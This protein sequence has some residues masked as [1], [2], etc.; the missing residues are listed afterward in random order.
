MTKFFSTISIICLFIS[1]LLFYSCKKKTDEPEGKPYMTGPLS[2]NIPP[3]VY[4]SR[5]YTFIAS[6]I[7]S[8]QGVSYKWGATGF[9]PDSCFVQTYTST[10]PDKTGPFSIS[11]SAMYEGYT[12]LS[13]TQVVVVIDSL[14]WDCVTEVVEG[15]GFIQDPRDGAIYHTRVY[16]DL[17][18][19]VQ[20]LNWEEAGNS[21]NKI[22]ALGTPFGRIYSWN[23]AVTG[24]SGGET[25]GVGATGLGGGPQ[26]VCP[27][28]WSVPTNEDWAHLATVVNGGESLSFF[29]NWNGI[30]DPLCTYAK[31]NGVLLWPYSPHNLKSNTALW[32]GLP[33]GNS[34]NY[35][36]RFENMDRYGFWLS[37]S[38]S[39]S[40]N[41]YYR[42]I[43]YNSNQFPYH[44]TDKHSF[45]A[46]VRCVRLIVTAPDS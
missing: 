41:G 43:N 15:S 32:N 14:F 44:F 42:Y 46:S 25:A 5:D 2:H 18:W 36:K 35:G 11:L 26:G 10:T 7:T 38:E 17:E 12:N 3:Y 39:D 40:N 13:I 16:G 21:Y 23:E 29:D 22:E 28:E 24:I 20:N 31:M 8:P 6:D 4:K 1:V 30:A 33:A 37:S 19:F 27:P 9:T 45:G 34:S